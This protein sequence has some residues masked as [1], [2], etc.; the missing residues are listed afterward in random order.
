M[1]STQPDPPPF[2]TLYEYISTPVLIHT[3][4]GRR[5]VGEPVTRLDGRYF[6]RGVENTNMTACI[7]SLSTLLNTRKDGIW[8]LVSL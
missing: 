5:G 4:K 8:G 6:T 1:L 2:Y 3:G 7:S